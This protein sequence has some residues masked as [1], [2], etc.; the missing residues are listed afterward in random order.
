MSNRLP[1]Y[2]L[3]IQNIIFK[4]FDVC[5]KVYFGMTSRNPS[6]FTISLFLY[7]YSQRPKEKN[8]K[9]LVTIK[10]SFI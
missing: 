9:S 10:T 8:A 3:L 4:S 5:Q 6:E 7:F 1:C 2:R